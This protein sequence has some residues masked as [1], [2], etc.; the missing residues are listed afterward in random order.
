[1]SILKIS[2]ISDKMLADIPSAAA[3]LPHYSGVMVV[4]TDTDVGKTLVAGAIGRYFRKYGWKVAVFKPAATGCRRDRGELISSDAEFLAA[5]ADTSQ[6]LRQITPVTYHEPLA[7]NVA[8][9]RSGEAVD[10]G[11]IFDA[12]RSLGEHGDIVVVEGIGG[13]LCPISDE[14]WVIHFAKAIALPVVI[15]ARAGLG[16]INH[17]LLTL[18][19]ARSAGLNVAGVIINRYRP[20][21]D[22]DISTQTNPSQIARLGDVNVLAL[23]PDEQ[24][25]NVAQATIGPDTEFVIEQVDW[26][27][28]VSIADC[29]LRNAD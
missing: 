22:D 8:A 14:F 17:T 7:P 18:H 10:I 21:G 25:N 29:E 24:A 6:T 13:L 4:G 9:H 19:A 20:E 12:Y 1:M 16:T 11:A 26:E 27:K 2:K 23:L 3:D 15:V 5:C 28:I